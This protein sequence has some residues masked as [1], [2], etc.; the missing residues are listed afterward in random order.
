[1]HFDSSSRIAHKDHACNNS[2]CASAN[3]DE[4]SSIAILTCTARLHAKM[5][6]L[7]RNDFHLED[8]L[9]VCRQ[10][11]IL[12]V[13]MPLE[14]TAWKKG[15]LVVLLLAASASWQQ[16][17]SADSQEEQARIQGDENTL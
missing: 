9:L 17:V 16:K 1:M 12:F 2:S 5:S 6:C 4:G 10:I 13:Q 15:G 3:L 8:L 11:I 14:K 7:V